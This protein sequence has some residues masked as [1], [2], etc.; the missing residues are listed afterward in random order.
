MYSAG[1]YSIALYKKVKELIWT[2][3]SDEFPRYYDGV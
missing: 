3:T 2:I 1:K